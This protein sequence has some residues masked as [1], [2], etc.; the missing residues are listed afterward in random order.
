MITTAP[1]RATPSGQPAVGPTRAAG[2]EVIDGRVSPASAD[3]QV[4][5]GLGNPGARHVGT[6]HNVGHDVAERVRERLGGS[7]IAHDGASIARATWKDTN[8][9]VVRLDTAMNRSGDAIRKLAQQ[10]GFAAQ[11]CIL[12]HDD[13]DLPLGAVRTRMRGSAGGHRG[14]ASVL[15]AF[16]T[17]AVRRVKLGV[18]RPREANVRD[19]VLERFTEA[20]RAAVD[21]ACTLAADRVIDLLTERRRRD[22]RETRE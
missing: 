22:A 18:G 14:V 10:L 5:L 19:Y 8:V 2:D 6:P 20:D 12:V 16:Q 13:L 11:D 21:Q 7:W 1:L 4:V 15:D 3:L 9:C 17:D